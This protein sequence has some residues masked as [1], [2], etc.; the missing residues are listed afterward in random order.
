MHFKNEIDYKIDVRG[1]KI[2]TK[3]E[4]P[5]LGGG[6]TFCKYRSPNI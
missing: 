1:I 2:I 3:K 4:P 6:L 5:L